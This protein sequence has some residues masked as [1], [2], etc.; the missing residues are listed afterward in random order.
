M[1]W[2]RQHIPVIG[3]RIIQDQIRNQFEDFASD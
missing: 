3:A 2:R 1:S